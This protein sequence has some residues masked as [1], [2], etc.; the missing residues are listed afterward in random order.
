MQTQ[1]SCPQ[2]RAPIVVDVQQIIDVGRQPELKQLM[3]A[4]ALNVAMCSQCGWG[5][6]LGMPLVYHDPAHDLLISFVPMELNLPMTEQERVV[7]QMVRQVVD[8]TPPEK[9]RAYMLQPQQMFRYQ[10]LLEKVLETEGVTPEMLARQREQVALLREMIT[11]EESTLSGLIGAN[12]DRIDAVFLT[13]LQSALDSASQA[14]RQGELVALTNL[15]ARLLDETEAGQQLLRQ[16]VAL[17]HFNQDAKKANGVTPQLLLK[18]ILANK[19]DAAAWQTI[20]T[21]GGAGLSYEFF[22]LLSQEVEKA[23]R[24]KDK[25]L[26]AQLTELRSQ[27][28]GLYDAM[29]EESRQV[30]AR[31]DETLQALMQ[32]PDVQAEVRARLDEIDDAFLYVLDQTI[33][34]ARA[35][36]RRDME[37]ILTSIQNAVED[38]MQEGIP[39]PVRFVSQLLMLD[40]AESA[41]R[42]LDENPGLV[43]QDLLALLQGLARNKEADP[44]LSARARQLE[45]MV[46]MRVR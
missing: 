41:R 9:R 3:L 8:N 10:T 43:N 21:S 40:S 5:G 20:A 18:H 26:A 35:S 11:A 6:Q 17:H 33:E 38:V 36:G 15:Q 34:Q 31:A 27:L 4:G 16:R 2:C 32:A 37:A 7:G 23:A 44:N 30:I 46:A 14:N 25:A 22:T 29:Q 28:L 39:E 24:N 12:Q 13:L 42:A 19:D 45:G 1:I